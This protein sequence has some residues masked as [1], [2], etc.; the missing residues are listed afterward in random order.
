MTIV[1]LER[2]LK[3]DASYQNGRE[4][5]II[6]KT[7]TFYKGMNNQPYQALPGNI[8]VVC[9]TLKTPKCKLVLFWLYAFGNHEKG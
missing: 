2:V 7:N 6:R 5:N 1:I 4:Y 3:T 9:T 8:A